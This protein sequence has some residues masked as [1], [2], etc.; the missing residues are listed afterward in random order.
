M[1]SNIRIEKICQHC[2]NTFTAKTTVTK[3]CGDRCAKL[4]YKKR[5]REEKI[6]A[7]VAKQKE[8]RLKP[9]KELEAKKYLSID[10]AC[11]FIGVSRWTLWRAL[12][13]NDD[14]KIRKIG[15]RRIIDRDELEQMIR[16]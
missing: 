16:I 6:G 7:S 4:N 12:K 5:K 2:G 11:Q 15:N 9:Y 1:S 10:E 13:N 14:V 8:E 3:F